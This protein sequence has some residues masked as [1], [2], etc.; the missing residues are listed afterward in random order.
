MVD[1]NRDIIEIYN[2]AEASFPL[3]EVAEPGFSSDNG[4][5]FIG[6]TGENRLIGGF[7]NSDLSGE[8]IRLKH[9]FQNLIANSGVES[10]T[11]GTKVV[12]DGGWQTYLANVEQSIIAVSGTYSAKITFPSSSINGYFATSIGVFKKQGEY[13]FTFYYQC[14]SGNGVVYGVIQ[15]NED[16]YTILDSFILDNTVDDTWKLAII[17]AIIP[18]SHWG[19]ASKFGIIATDNNASQW[20]F[21]EFLAQEGYRLATTWHPAPIWDS[22]S[23]ESVMQPLTFC[24]ANQ[25]PYRIISGERTL[26]NTDFFVECSSA[27]PFAVTLP[28]AIGIIGRPYEVKNVGS[29]EITVQTS[30]AQMIDG[31]PTKT[32]AQFDH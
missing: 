8:N 15:E 10:W 26:D 7:L 25:D 6:K 12:P 28:T 23:G 22:G 32:L 27:S 2:G 3:L 18:E 14:L 13:T 30:S 4:R 16:D 17:T 29:G 11:V 31:T 5:L 21:D 20:L 9:S 1:R 24:Y 19:K